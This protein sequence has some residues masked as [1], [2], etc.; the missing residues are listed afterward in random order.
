M[1]FE[2]LRER[3]KLG[4]ARMAGFYLAVVGFVFFW[5]L[6]FNFQL[7]AVFVGWF[8]PELSSTTHFVH[9]IGLASFVWVWGLAMLAQLYRPAKRVTAMQV[10]VLLVLADA[11]VSVV[12]GVATTESLLFFGP[13]LLAAV[14]HP[15]RDE[16]FGFA[17]VSREDIDPVVLAVAALAVVP[18]G[19]YVLG[20]LTLQATLDDSHVAL[21]HYST[22][23]YFSV[24]MVGL[25]FL[26]AV[27]T[28]G[29]RFPAYAAAV[30]AL[31]LAAASVFYPTASGLD[32]LWS[33][34]ATVWALALVGAYEWSVRRDTVNST[35]TAPER[36]N[37]SP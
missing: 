19:L 13:T 32:T 35:A 17:R 20:Q 29:R 22:M 34:L 24:S 28:R 4:L 2:S 6:A 15:A 3:S 36:P 1:A 25:V 18:V 12:A 26:A 11:S 14:L 23:G 16:V 30:M 21:T 37:V 27:R 33:G 9:N 10:A 7:W 8:D 5:L 31:G